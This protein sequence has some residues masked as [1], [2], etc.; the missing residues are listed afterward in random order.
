MVLQEGGSPSARAEELQRSLQQELHDAK[1]QAAA[2]AATRRE[3]EQ[4]LADLQAQTQEVARQLEAFK[5]EQPQLASP[6]REGEDLKIMA[7]TPQSL[8]IVL[9][10]LTLEVTHAGTVCIMIGVT[11]VM[12][13]TL[14]NS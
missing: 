9:T 6:K 10:E 12:I 14:S 4:T 11:T 5:V 1:Q 2:A 8:A 13:D 7:E 3:A